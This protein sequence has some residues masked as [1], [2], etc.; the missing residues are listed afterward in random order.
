MEPFAAC[1][2]SVTDPPDCA[3]IV[4]EPGQSIPCGLEV[5]RPV[6]LPVGMAVTRKLPGGGGGW[7]GAKSAVTVWSASML[8]LQEPVPE[9]SPCQP[10]KVFFASAVAAST[11]VAPA[12][13]CWQSAWQENDG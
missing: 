13:L 3:V 10:A 1:A 7:L 5:T 9:Q 2:V 4:H 6:P 11:T 12:M 8:T